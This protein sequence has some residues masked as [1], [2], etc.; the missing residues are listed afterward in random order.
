MT[1]EKTGEF[2]E[3]SVDAKKVEETKNAFIE[4]GQKMEKKVY[5]VPGKKNTAQSILAFLENDAKF[6]AHESLGIVKAHEDVT[7][8]LPKGNKEFYL[9]SLCIE[10]VAYYLSKYE[11][12]GLADAT[13]FKDNLFMPINEAMAA[14]QEDKNTAEQ[15]QL[16]W[17]AAAQGVNVLIVTGKPL[18]SYLLR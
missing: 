4:F 5:L 14:I 18:P 16:E 3:S 6:A 12:K 8:N 15:L 17:A 1:V 10:A 13:S 2:N 7:A 11:G 9:G